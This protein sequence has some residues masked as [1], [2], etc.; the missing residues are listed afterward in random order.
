MTVKVVAFVTAAMGV[1]VIVKDRWGYLYFP[2][3]FRGTS[4]IIGPLLAVL[5]LLVMVIPVLKIV[6]AVGLF[7]VRRWA[8]ISAIVVLTLD[9]VIRLQSAV[10]MCIFSLTHPIP[11]MP[12]SVSQENVVV[13]VV[14]MGP[15]YVVSIVGILIVLILFQKPI[16]KLFEEG[17]KVA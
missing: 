9:F 10:R 11:P 14:N 6:V 8:W 13:R 7:N 5:S 17:R 3:A 1:F 2:M 16:S 15:T 4:E 12:M